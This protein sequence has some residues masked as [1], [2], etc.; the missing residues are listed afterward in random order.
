MIHDQSQRLAKKLEQYDQLQ[1]NK[2]R[3]T[4]LEPVRQKLSTASQGLMA[5]T[6]YVLVLQKKCDAGRVPRTFVSDLT[7]K[8]TAVRERAATAAS[9]EDWCGGRDVAALMKSA[10]EATKQLKQLAADA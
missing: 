2:Q 9:A 1:R 8:L 5:A 4:Q 3:A 10:E 6:N 7:G